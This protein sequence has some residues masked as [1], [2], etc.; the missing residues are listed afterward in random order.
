[1]GEE[2]SVYTEVLK[3]NTGATIPA[4]GLG[5]WQSKPNEVAEA[6]YIALKAGYR[7]IDTAWVYDNENEV[8]EGI[9]KSGVP[10]SEIFITAKLWCTHQR[11]PEEAL[12]RSLQNL[13][14]EYV[15][16]YLVHWPVPLNPHGNDP[17]FPKKEDGSRDHDLEWN[18]IKTWHELQK[19]PKSK[20]RAIGVSNCSI[21]FITDLLADPL[22]TVVP[23]TNQVELHP[24]LPQHELLEFAKSKGI[25]LQAY[26][27]LGSTASP[28][29]TD[30]D[31]LKIADKH[32]ANPGQVL[33]S[34][35]VKRGV[36]VLPKSVHEQRIKDNFIK[37]DL[38]EEDFNVLNNLHNKISQRIIKPP[39]GVDLKFPVW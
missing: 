36:A 35:Q 28:L 12:D 22:T 39:W 11:K 19:I 24:Y 20:A 31:I 8:G 5:T 38:D 27:P 18:Y 13:G 30:E 29:L 26:S 33:I 17:K 1:V 10:R 25:I 2:M 7:H 32:H 6:V 16:L 14:L 21:P 15:D 34:W 3:L 4:V 9:K 37:V 23:A